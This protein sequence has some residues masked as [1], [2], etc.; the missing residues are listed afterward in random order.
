MIRN[1]MMWNERSSGMIIS[2]SPPVPCI[3]QRLG[4][5]AGEKEEGTGSKER[6]SQQ[7]PGIT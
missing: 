1:V 3:A 2:G 4:L 6:Q 5:Q 7:V